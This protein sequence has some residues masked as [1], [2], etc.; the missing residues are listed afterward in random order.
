MRI[1]VAGEKRPSEEFGRFVICRE[2]GWDWWTFENQPSFFIEEIAIILKQESQ[3]NA[4]DLSRTNSE[5]PSQPESSALEP[6]KI[7]R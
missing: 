6:F 5:L 1:L 4:M 7:E 2:M 3:K